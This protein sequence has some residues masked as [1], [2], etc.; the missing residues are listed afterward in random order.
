MRR[1]VRA[2]GYGLF[3]DLVV[4]EAYR[5]VSTL[6]PSVNFVEVFDTLLTLNCGLGSV[7]H[8]S[9]RAPHQKRFVVAALKS[10]DRS[11][12]PSPAA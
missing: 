7:L 12:A 4:A 5:G 1:E 2:L 11:F 8:G 6:P 3:I 10:A 9:R